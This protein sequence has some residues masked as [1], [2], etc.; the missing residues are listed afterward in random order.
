MLTV[1]PALVVVCT[2]QGKARQAGVKLDRD[3][4]TWIDVGTAAM[5]MM[6]AAQELGL[7]TCPVTSFSAAGL[8]VALDLPAEVVPELLLTLGRPAPGTATGRAGAR[9]RIEVDEL[10]DWER[11]GD[12]RRGAGP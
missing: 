4:T 1:P 12:A 5:N 8:A 10:I 9:E 3:P 7:G 6:L 2:D 11:I